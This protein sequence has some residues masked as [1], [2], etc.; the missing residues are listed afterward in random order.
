MNFSFIFLCFKF[1]LDHIFFHLI[2]SHIVKISRTVR[3]FIDKYTVKKM[4]EADALKIIHVSCVIEIG[5]P[6]FRCLHASTDDTT[7]V[8]CCYV[9]SLS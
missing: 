8:A 5:V 6:T 1:K 3:H 4:D 7:S 9:F 2:S